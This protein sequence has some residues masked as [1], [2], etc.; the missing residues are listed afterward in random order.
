MTRMLASTPLPVALRCGDVLTSRDL[1]ASMG[2]LKLPTPILHG[3]AD[4]SVPVEFGCMSAQ[5]IPH[6]R[7]V[8]IPGG[9]HALFFTHR[10]RI[11]IEICGWLTEE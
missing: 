3:D 9:P 7:H 1:R 4:A 8:E 5:A 6:A 10:E 2:E 11:L